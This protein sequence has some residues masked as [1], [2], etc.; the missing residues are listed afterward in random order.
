AGDVQQG[1]VVADDLRQGDQALLI[2][3]R[4]GNRD[5]EKFRGGERRGLRRFRGFDAVG[6]RH[7]VHFFTHFLDV[8]QGEGKFGRIGGELHG[9]PAQNEEVHLLHLHSVGAGRE[10]RNGEIARIIG[11]CGKRRLPQTFKFY[12]NPGN[13]DSVFV[14]NPSAQGYWRICGNDA[15]NVQKRQQG[16]RNSQT[17]GHKKAL[18][19]AE[20]L[21]LF[22]R[23]NL[24]DQIITWSPSVNRKSGCRAAALQKFTSACLLLLR[25]FASLPPPPALP[26]TARSAP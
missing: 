1:L 2:V 14:Q 18:W 21:P 19:S 5:I 13:G 4:T 22:L 20:A 16:N 7:H 9:L 11:Q 25:P 17:L 12:L 24:G 26:P 6:V 23:P 10:A 15:P 3:M 8:I